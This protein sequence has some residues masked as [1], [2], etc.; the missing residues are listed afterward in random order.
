MHG[1]REVEALKSLRK[2]ISEIEEEIE[3]EDDSADEDENE[4]R[5]R[6]SE[7]ENRSRR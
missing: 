4:R 7:Y 5:Q 3:E 2:E 1:Q 6:L